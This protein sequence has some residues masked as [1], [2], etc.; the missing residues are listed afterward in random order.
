M[1]GKI[2]A[3]AIPQVILGFIDSQKKIRSRSGKE[4]K[5]KPNRKRKHYKAVIGEVVVYIWEMT[6]N[7]L[8]EIKTTTVSSEFNIN[9]SYLSRKFKEV[10]ELNLCDFIQW[11]KIQRAISLMHQDI[12]IRQFDVYTGIKPLRIESLSEVLGFSSPEYFSRCFKKWMYIPPHRYRECIKLNDL[13]ITLVSCA[14]G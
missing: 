7:D 3:K 5:N 13:S 10:C 9:T 6:I 11:V 14:A 8:K 4:D 12:L 1:T 2:S